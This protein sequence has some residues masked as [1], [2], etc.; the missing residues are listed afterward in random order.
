MYVVIVLGL[1]EG[2]SAVFA[3]SRRWVGKWVL[4]RREG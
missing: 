1:K 4:G 3:R 2:W